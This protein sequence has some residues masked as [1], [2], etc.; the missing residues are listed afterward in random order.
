MEQR[1]FLITAKMPDLNGIWGKRGLSHS[2]GFCSVPAKQNKLQQWI[3]DIIDTIEV[4]EKVKIEG[5]IDVEALKKEMTGGFN[6]KEKEEFY[7]SLDKG[8]DD[9]ENGRVVPHD[10][11][12]KMVQERLKK[13]GL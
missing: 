13:Y 6:R 5:G 12:M 4:G 9:M 7:E 8:I 10:D 3:C 11:A 2:C 1:F